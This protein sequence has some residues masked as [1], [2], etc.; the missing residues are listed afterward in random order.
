MPI[1]LTLLFGIIIGVL[2]REV[3][4]RRKRAALMATALSDAQRAIIA[5]KMPIAAKLP[6][7]LRARFEGLVNRFLDEIKFHGAEDFEITNEVRTLIAAQACFLIVN[8]DNRWFKTLKTI[9]VYPAAFKSKL[10]SHDGHVTHEN[11]QVRSG[12]SWSRGQVVL[13][14][15][16]AAY[17]AFIDAD[18]H[19]VVMHEFAHQ[20][21]DQTGQTDGAPL[22]D[23]DH[24]A[25]EWGRVF[26][27]AYDRLR[28][29]AASGRGSLLDHYGATKPAEFFAV[30]TEV[31]FEKPEKLR[32]EEPA[33]YGQLARYYNLDPAGWD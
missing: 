24:N 5:E 31:F 8:K 17:G 1:L 32:E 27:E 4:T 11:E 3:M 6:D 2:A 15:D 21:D 29:D 23:P 14:W 20:L 25:R 19:N 13:A 18:G 16:H 30:A 9:F 7:A 22:L 28:S 12:E 26:Q 33:L 10:K